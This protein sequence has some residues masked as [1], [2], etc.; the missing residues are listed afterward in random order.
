MNDNTF[1][2]RSG[3]TVQKWAPAERGQ[4]NG[5]KGTF[6]DPSPICLVIDADAGMRR[7]LRGPLETDGYRMVEA[8]NG[9]DALAEASRC[10]PEVILLDP[11]LPDIEGLE[12]M[13]HIHKWSRTPVLVISISNR[14]Q[15]KIEMLDAGAN[16]YIVKPFN[17]G[18]LLARVRAALRH[19]LRHNSKP[20]YKRGS[21]EVDLISRDVR[22]SGERV[23][24]TRT[25]YAFLRLFVSHAGKVLTHKQILTAIW[26]QYASKANH[27]LRVYIAHL[28]SKLEPNRSSPEI[29]LTESGVGY[30]LAEDCSEA[31]N[32]T[33]L[34]LESASR[35]AISP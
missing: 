11:D 8:G 17:V 9:N 6:L 34:D 24:L 10:R 27:Y 4:I 13:Q 23:N 5:S 22:K 28:R 20:I 1:I 3:T 30:R 2:S 14:E 33:A 19:D 31:V 26:G 18:E 7:L 29:L 21:L 35:F 25:E 16:D 12:L 32:G 15:D